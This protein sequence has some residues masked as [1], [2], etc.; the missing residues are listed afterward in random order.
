MALVS[1]TLRGIACPAPRHRFWCKVAA[2]LALGCVVASGKATAQAP[3][4]RAREDYLRPSELNRL[5]PP[6]PGEGE[7]WQGP[8]T[9]PVES[10]LGSSHLTVLE[11]V[12]ATEHVRVDASGITRIQPPSGEIP[13]TLDGYTAGE[14]YDVTWSEEVWDWHV[15]PNG[16]IYPSYL[17][18]VHEPRLASVWLDERTNGSN[19]DS[20]LGARVA[21]LRYGTRGGIRPQG[22][23]LGVEG[24]ALPRLTLNDDLRDLVATDYRAGVPITYSDG[25]WQYKLAYYHLSSHLGDEIMLADPTLQRINYTRDAI[26]LGVAYH[27]TPALRLYGEAAYSFR[28][29][30]GAEPW[31]FQFGFDYAPERP[32]GLAGAPFVAANVHLR[33]EVDF[34]GNFVFQTGWAWRGDSTRLFR[35]GVQYYNGKSPQYEFFD[36]FEEQFGIGMWLDF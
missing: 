12:T 32:T 8:Y 35:L 11:P 6:L 26:L 33:E 9:Q 27:L 22:L 36:Q 29:S 18:G 4:S 25:P 24:A 1:S 15:L 16:V 2:L 17:A 3:A 5:E 23:E 19:W 21:L 7:L 28:V 13:L 34:G 14:V 20:T 31:E 30:D 10:S